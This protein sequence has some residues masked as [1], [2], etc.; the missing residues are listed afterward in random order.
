MPLAIMGFLSRLRGG[1][2]D[3]KAIRV[4]INFL[5]RLRGGE[6]CDNFTIII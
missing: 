1:E 2:P 3:I 5:S 6:P 4:M